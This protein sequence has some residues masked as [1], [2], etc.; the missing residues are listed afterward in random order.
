MKP[1]HAPRRAIIRDW[2]TLPREQRQSVEQAAAFA[3]RSAATHSF[4][5]V[6]D[7]SA[8]I[9]IWLKPRIGRP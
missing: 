3:V 7:R 4:E 8:R 5:C 1:E 6:G 9:L 2:M